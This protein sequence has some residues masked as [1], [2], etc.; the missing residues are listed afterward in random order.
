[1]PEPMLKDPKGLIFVTHPDMPSEVNDIA[2]NG[3]IDEQLQEKGI[4]RRRLASGQSVDGAEEWVR[5]G[6]SKAPSGKS[7]MVI[8]YGG[9]RFVVVD[10]SEREL[11]DRCGI[12]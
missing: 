1:M 12:H 9:N 5:E 4:E 6:M 11:E 3:V 8:W 7:S 2:I 10:I